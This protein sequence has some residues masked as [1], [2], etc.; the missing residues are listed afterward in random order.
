MN[1]YIELQM[2]FDKMSKEEALNCLYDN[3][4]DADYNCDFVFNEI[5]IGC[6]CDVGIPDECME[7]DCRHC[8]TVAINKAKQ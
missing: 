3:K 7:E 4:E 2:I 5:K 8:W 6:P 1:K